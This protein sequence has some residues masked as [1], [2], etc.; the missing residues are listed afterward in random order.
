VT[1][2]IDP[3]PHAQAA[4]RR[5]FEGWGA[6]IGSTLSA[7]AGA[8][9]QLTGRLYGRAR[10][11]GGAAVADFQARPEH[12]RWRAYAMGCYG[13]LVVATFA[14]QLYTENKLGAVVRVQR[15]E[16]PALTQIFV[17]NDSDETWR[18]V[19]ITLNGI[20]SYE[21]L[22]V[23]PGGHVLLPV[24]RFALFD[25]KGHASYPPKNVEPQALTID[26]REGHFETDF[27][28]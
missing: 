11:R 25:N 6:A 10:E 21:T 9:I 26:T 19:K 13:V 23:L 7:F 27:R 24:D 16:M 28:K 17:R 14:A 20:Y 4:K 1:A 18:G 8:L 22:Q 2:V 15:V 3:P 5:P 12:S